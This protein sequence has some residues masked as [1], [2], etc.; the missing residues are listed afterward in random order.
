[1]VHSQI[2][3]LDQYMLWSFAFGHLLE[4]VQLSAHRPGYHTPHNL[5]ITHNRPMQDQEEVLSRHLLASLQ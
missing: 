1:M 4:S 3:C 2:L 5:S